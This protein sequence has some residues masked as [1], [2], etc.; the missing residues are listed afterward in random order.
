MTRPSGVGVR[1]KSPGTSDLR[2]PDAIYELPYLVHLWRGVCGYTPS[3]A[4]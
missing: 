2:Q 3:Q 4:S 1:R